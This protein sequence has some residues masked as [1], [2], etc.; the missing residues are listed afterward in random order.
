MENGGWWMED[1]DGGWRTEI[2]DGGQ[3]WRMQLVEVM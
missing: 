1:R 2:E 3:I